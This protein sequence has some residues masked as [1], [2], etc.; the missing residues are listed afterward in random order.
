MCAARELGLICFS[1]PFDETAV[2][3]LEE[4]D[5]P[6]YKIASFE[7]THLP[8]IKNVAATGKPGYNRRLDAPREAGLA[9]SVEP[10]LDLGNW[11]VTEDRVQ[12]YLAAV[13]DNQPEYLEYSL[14]PPLALSNANT[15]GKDFF[16]SDPQ[17]ARVRNLPRGQV[18]RSDRGHSPLRQAQTTRKY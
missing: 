13:G 5:V 14:A 1:T 7:N 18:W 4:L 12:R 2:D 9:V 6:A 15:M 11:T 3:F 17:P 8:L 10:E 16:G